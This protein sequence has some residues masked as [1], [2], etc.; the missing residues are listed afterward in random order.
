MLLPM[1]AYAVVLFNSV[2]L[3]T[4]H[5]LRTA[6]QHSDSSGFAEDS[7][8][9]LPLNH[10]QVLLPI[11]IGTF[12][13]IHFKAIYLCVLLQGGLSNGNRNKMSG[14]YITKYLTINFRFYSFMISE[15]L[16]K[17]LVFY[18]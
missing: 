18:Y 8:D 13:N 9:C 6:S 12:V 14:M 15:Y 16:K 2:F 1:Q 4:D 3:L 11:L 5:L 10:L 17:I 7:A